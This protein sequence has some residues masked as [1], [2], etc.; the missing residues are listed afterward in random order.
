VTL[1]EQLLRFQRNLMP[2]CS[3]VK[4]FEKVQEDSS[5]TLGSEDDVTACFEMSGS[6]HTATHDIPAV[7]MLRYLISFTCQINLKV[8]Q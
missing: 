2:L 4:Q 5:W 6:T 1:N 3:R 7:E 8:P